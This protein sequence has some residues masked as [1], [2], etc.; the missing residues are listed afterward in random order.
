MKTEK[1]KLNLGCGKDIREDYINVDKCKYKGIDKV[2][3]LDVY[4]YPFE[5]NS[6]DEIIIFNCLEHLKDWQKAFKEM[7]RILK[8]GG[9]LHI[10]VPHFSAPH[11]NSEFHITRFYWHSFSMKRFYQSKVTALENAELYGDM[12]LVS[13]HLNFTKGLLFWNYLVE[14]LINLNWFIPVFYEHTCLCYLLP[15]EELEFKMVKVK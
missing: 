5:D 3:D 4:P 10:K 15:A 11:S 12:K 6:A 9:K 1:V 8:K 7:V 2:W 13:K 14:P